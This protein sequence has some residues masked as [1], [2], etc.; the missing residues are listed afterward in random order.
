MAK[1]QKKSVEKAV[2]FK[3]PEPVKKE[4]RWEFFKS[5]L[6]FSNLEN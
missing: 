6:K 3:E 4:E 1:K 2:E 5:F